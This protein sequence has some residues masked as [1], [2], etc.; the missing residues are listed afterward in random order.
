MQYVKVG[1]GPEK[2]SGKQVLV[3]VLE[4]EGVKLRLGATLSQEKLPDSAFSC[5]VLG[6]CE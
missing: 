3:Q 2:F 1:S 5:C 4:G 6:N